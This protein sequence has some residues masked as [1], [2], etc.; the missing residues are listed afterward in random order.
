[1]RAGFWGKYYSLK[2]TKRYECSVLGTI[3]CFG[4]LLVNN[5]KKTNVDAYWLLP[6]I[7]FP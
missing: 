1:M 2:W 3:E 6:K 4:V 5:G 7:E